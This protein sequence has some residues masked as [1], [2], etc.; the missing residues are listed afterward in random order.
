MNSDLSSVLDVQEPE[1]SPPE[2]DL[3]EEAP[4][5]PNYICIIASPFISLLSF[6]IYLLFLVWIINVS[7]KK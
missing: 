3:P 2:D 4:P 7:G 5:E 1:Q 6:I